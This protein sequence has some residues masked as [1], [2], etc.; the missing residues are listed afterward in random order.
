M[1]SAER[2]QLIAEREPLPAAAEDIAT[3]IGEAVLVEF[4]D[5]ASDLE[6]HAEKTEKLYRDLGMD[7]EREAFAYRTVACDIRKRIEFMK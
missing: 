7:G 4:D 1:T 2:L 6:H 3:R 5:V